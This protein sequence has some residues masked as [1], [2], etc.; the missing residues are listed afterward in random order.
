MG[1]IAWVYSSEI[2]PMKL[3]AQG[4]SMGVAV[5]RITSGLISM[6]FISLY[7]GISIGGTFLM[8]A[9]IG[10]VA[11]VFFYTLF[12]ETRGK[13]LGEMELLFGTFSKWRS[14]SRK[15][16]KEKAEID[17]TNYHIQMETWGTL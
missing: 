10:A 11:W 3:R 5:N 17:S 15:L 12:I 7:K 2:F 9:G 13:T 4:F 1:P 6:T 14:T 8:C 16:K